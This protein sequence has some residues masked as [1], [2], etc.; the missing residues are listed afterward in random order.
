VTFHGEERVSEWD[1]RVW[2]L[3]IVPLS[4]IEKLE[5]FDTIL[6]HEKGRRNVFC[7]NDATQQEKL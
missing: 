5:I 2:L 3:S 1:M 6:E 7:G 4:E